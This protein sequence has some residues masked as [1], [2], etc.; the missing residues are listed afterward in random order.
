VGGGVDGAAG[1]HLAGGGRVVEQHLN[2]RGEAVGAGTGQHGR[3]GQRPIPVQHLVDH[4]HR[5]AGERRLLEHERLGVACGR[6]REHLGA[7]VGGAHHRRRL[8]TG[9][10]DP[11]SQAAAVEQPAQPAPVVDRADQHQTGVRDPGRQLGERVDQQVDALLP[12]DPADEEDHPIGARD[13]VLVAEGADRG[14]VRR[15]GRHPGRDDEDPVRVDRHAEPLQH[16]PGR[17]HQG[18]RATEQ[19]DVGGVQY[20]VPAPRSRRGCGRARHAQPVRVEAQVGGEGGLRQ[21]V[22]VGVRM[23]VGV[24]GLHERHA[25]MPGGEHAEETDRSRR[26]HVDDLG[27]GGRDL[28]QCTGGPGVAQQPA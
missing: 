25:E 24:V 27:G 1:S 16:R 9:D 5:Q 28:L 13:G 22:R 11:G 10:H 21:L 6:E 17:D 20:R 18:G 26:V 2:A 4:D 23:Q 12:V 7:T 8:L 3:P 14:R 15:P 19:Q